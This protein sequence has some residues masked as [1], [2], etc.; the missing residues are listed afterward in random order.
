MM[1]KRAV[2]RFQSAAEA[3]DA[4]SPYVAGSSPTAQR[5]KNTASWQRGQLTLPELT[6]RRRRYFPRAVASVALAA[7]VIVIILAWPS[8]F[9]RHGGQIAIE[10]GPGEEEK[11]NEGGK[12]QGGQLD[13]A[14]ADEGPKLEHDPNVLTVSQDKK[15]GGQFRT[16]SEAMTKVKP[17]QTIRVLDGAVYREAIGIVS[18]SQHAGITLEAI[19]GATVEVTAERGVGFLIKGVPGVTVRGFR[20]CSSAKQEAF[21]VAVLH[22]SPGTR[23]EYLDLEGG[24]T[25]VLQGL[26][27]EKL[28]LADTDP[29]LVLQ[30]CAFRQVT[31]AVRLSGLGDDYRMPELNRRVV[32]RNNRFTRCA[33]AIRVRGAAGQVQVVGNRISH[34]NISAIQLEN[35]QEPAEE[36]LIA[37]NTLLENT[38][39]IRFWDDKDKDY[40]GRKI[41]VRN[42]LFLGTLQEDM[43]FTDSGGNPKKPRGSGDGASLHGVWKLDHNWYEGKPPTAA[44]P[45]P[46]LIPPGKKDVRHDE[47]PL[48]SRDPNNTDFLRPG[49][50]S[51]LATKGAS[52]EDPSLPSYVGAIPPEGVT[53]WNWDRTWRMPRPAQLLTV[54]KD[55]KDG[56]MYRSIGEALKDAKPWATIRVLDKAEY[57]ESLRID[58]PT[59]YEGLTL[60]AP[61][62]ATL[63]LPPGAQRSLAILGVRYVLIRG[64][65]FRDVEGKPGTPFVLASSHSPGLHFQNL[66]LQSKNHLYG[67]VLHQVQIGPGEP[68][69]VVA[70]CSVQVGHTGIT[71]AGSS[72]KSPTSNSPC[73][74]ISIRENRVWGA[75]KGI[76]IQGTVSDTHV[77]GNLLWGCS[78]GALQLENLA[79]NSDRIL[80]ANNTAFESSAA[81]R[82]WDDPPFREVRRGQV[83][84]RNNLFFEASHGDMMAFRGGEGGMGNVSDVTNKS[85]AAHW[86]FGQNGRD[87]SGTMQLIPLVSGDIKIDQLEVISRE[88]SHADFMRP[89]ANSPMGKEGA[90]KDDSTLPIY[91]GAVPPKGVEPWDWDRTWRAR[92]SRSNLD[93]SVAGDKK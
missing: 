88:A 48:L 83:E 24:Q 90:G 60:E 82:I 65:R 10:T 72:I 61:Q 75:D 26:E 37:N 45:D 35:L 40:R 68:G 42:N 55:A 20:L 50:D 74:R 81:F 70:K 33:Q 25:S 63:L 34:C 84:L 58:N 91:I 38:R 62:Q 67:I 77:V 2:D 69:V 12:S 27:V 15:D 73:S 44:K 7:A 23:L 64:L 13:K 49:K 86:R 8:F 54:S 31:L 5:F 32:I 11:D 79:V 6:T 28:D 39:G 66:D 21:L 87:L 80:L 85:I 18:P 43:L 78:Q 92:I 89:P 52:Q 41:E 71:V 46:A 16:M 53:P 22:R 57:P 17:N 36:I 1:A 9:P 76:V 56:G 30:D 4:L 93:K 47:I 14:S 3:A 51:P 19:R 59:Q 29:P